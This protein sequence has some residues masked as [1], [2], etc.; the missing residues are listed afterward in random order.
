MYQHKPYNQQQQKKKKLL[1]KKKS[2]KKGRI[3]NKEEW[4]NHL[5]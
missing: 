4:K 5:F 1:Q 3:S 2:K